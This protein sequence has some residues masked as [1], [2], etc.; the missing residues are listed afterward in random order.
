[1]V[2][3]CHISLIDLHNPFDHKDSCII[4]LSREIDPKL[5][6]VEFSS[7]P[8]EFGLVVFFVQDP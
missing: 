4:V 2:R 7:F 6:D 3:R 8:A 1:M 5:Y